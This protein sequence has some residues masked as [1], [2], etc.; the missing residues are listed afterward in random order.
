[1]VWYFIG[2]SLTRKI[3]FQHSK[4]N[5]VSLGGIVISSTS[6]IKLALKG[7]GQAIL[8]NFVSFSQLIV[9]VKSWSHN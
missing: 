3:V 6:V 5:F 2:A 8:G 1:M 7:L 9:D 4:T